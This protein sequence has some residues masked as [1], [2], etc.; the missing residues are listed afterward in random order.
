MRA[1][2]MLH[3]IDDSGSVVSVSAD[4][5]RSLVRAAR[6]AGHELV[7]LLDL[8][9]GK[10]EGDALALTFDDAF[11]SVATVAAPLLRTLGVPAT[12]FVP[13]Q[14]PGKD[15]AWPG[16][17]PSVPSVPIMRWEA[18]RRLAAEGW[19]I[20]SHG[21]RHPDLRRLD[22]RAL[23]EELAGSKFEI[24]QRVG[25]APEVFAYPYGW[26][27]RRVLD[28]TR[29][30]FS[31]AVTTRMGTLEEMD[32]RLQVPRLDAYYLRN[33]RVHRWI[34]HRRFDAY[35]GVRGFLRRL[36]AHPG[37]IEVVA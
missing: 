18:V 37:E 19:S 15:N 29:R 6:D 28:F 30:H 23:D 24:A 31:Y 7:P 16:Q 22:D 10:V 1:V 20:E 17:D 25:R 11:E 13:T 8:L 34:G 26:F 33:E 2:V 9:R 21:V 27:D 35:V 4:Q 32:D 14:F 12:L 5:L 36:K 3:G